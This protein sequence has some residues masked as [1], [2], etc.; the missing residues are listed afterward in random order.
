VQASI[1]KRFSRFK[2]PLSITILIGVTAAFSLSPLVDPVHSDAAVRASLRAS[3]LYDLIAPASNVL[4]SLTLLTPAQY[5]QTFALCAAFVFVGG[6]VRDR[7][8]RRAFSLFRTARTAVRF[9][10]GTVAL[11]GIM[12]VVT[13]PMAAL[14]LSDSE[15]IA[16]DFHSHT[17]ASHDG[18]PGFD[19]E[20]NRN[21]HRSAGFDVAYVTDHRTFDGALDAMR[22]NPPAAGEGTVLLPGVELHDVGEHPL[23]LGVDPA[24]MT[25]T[26]PD[27][28]DAAVKA[29]G[30][31][32]PPLLLLTMPG[33]IK[34]I[35]SS[36]LAGE[37]R[38]AGIEI[39][40]GCPRGMAQTA[41]DHDRILALA[42][43]LHLAL[44]AGSDN[45]GWGRTAGAWS[46]LRLTGWREMSPASLDSAIRS[47]IIAGTNTSATVIARRTAA[48]STGAFQSAVGGASVVLM[49]LRTMNARERLSWIAWSWSLVLFSGV[50]ARLNR[51][52]LQ[53]GVRRRLKQRD[54]RPLV[55]VAAAV[56]A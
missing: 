30:G 51:R 36:E 24:R 43:R 32:V 29:D 39:A 46:V 31:P 19:A 54:R 55:D 35:P 17:S 9:L 21:W 53:L 15:L 8:E 25:I 10:L 22:H 28:H 4:D 2:W 16:V 37:V 38:I 56:Q 41:A 1:A 13:R 7:R 20:H 18:R 11:I 23:L 5:W 40:D 34:S 47:T 42:G 44:V 49:M 27:W 12:L 33:D 26:S 50:R 14:S 3:L 45:H 6:V 48:P 52:R